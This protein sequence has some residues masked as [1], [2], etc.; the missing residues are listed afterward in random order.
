MISLTVSEWWCLPQ[1]S[2]I[3]YRWMPMLWENSLCHCQ[4]VELPSTHAR[5][6]KKS[7]IKIKKGLTDGYLLDLRKLKL[8]NIKGG[9]DRQNVFYFFISDALDFCSWLWSSLFAVYICK[10]QILIFRGLL[11][12]QCIQKSLSLSFWVSFSGYFRSMIGAI[13]LY[14]DKL[15]SN[16][17]S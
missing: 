9:L 3:I 2:P 5:L 17:K 6:D 10:V 15:E 12:I 4:P 7:I 1:M 16:L 11:S 14:W 8:W 13:N